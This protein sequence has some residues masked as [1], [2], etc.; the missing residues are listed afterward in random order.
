MNQWNKYKYHTESTKSWFTWSMTLWGYQSAQLG[1][2]DACWILPPAA[3]VFSLPCSW[4][5]R[6]AANKIILVFEVPQVQLD[7]YH[8]FLLRFEGQL[9]LCVPSSRT[10]ACTL[11][12]VVRVPVALFCHFHH[13]RNPLLQLLLF[14]VL[15]LF[16]DKINSLC[17]LLNTILSVI[18]YFNDQLTFWK[19]FQRL[20]SSSPLTCLQQKQ[21]TRHPFQSLEKIVRRSFFRC[22]FIF[23]NKI[24]SCG[25]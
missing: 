8:F 14:F 6:F 21:H 24:R 25:I 18:A 22:A 3:C 1:C 10:R 9:C 11:C 7:N 2:P 15:L 4:F 12:A 23:A 5:S 20:R 16:P 13:L 19:Q 17:G